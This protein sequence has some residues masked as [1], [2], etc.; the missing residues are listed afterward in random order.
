MFNK[1]DNIQNYTVTE[2]IV[3][4]FLRN[5]NK[6]F[7]SQDDILDALKELGIVHSQ[8]AI[9]KSLKDLKQFPFVYR[10]TI[11]AICSTPRG[12]CLLNQDDYLKSLLYVI[13]QEKLLEHEYS[14][15]E[16][17]LPTPQM[18]IFWINTDAKK[19]ERALEL[20]QRSLYDCLLDVFY[21]DNRLIILLNHNS[22]RFTEISNIMKNFFSK[23]NARYLQI[24]DNE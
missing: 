20:F 9:S 18:F 5:R 2:Q 11:F 19:Q 13:Q 1:G 10:N 8:S 12:L 14:F 22:P 7:K 6:Y 21:V 3:Q 15:C 23:D 4:L 17:S 16:H 24:T